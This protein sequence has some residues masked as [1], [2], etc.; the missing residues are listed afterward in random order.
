MIGKQMRTL[1]NR[2]FLFIDCSKMTPL[3]K[4][5]LDASLEEADIRAFPASLLSP[6]ASILKDYNIISLLS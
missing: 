5:F 3:E 6:T 4:A 1:K 2:C